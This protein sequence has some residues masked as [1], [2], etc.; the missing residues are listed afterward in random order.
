M[1]AAEEENLER[2]QMSGRMYLP[3]AVRSGPVAAALVVTAEGV[4]EQVVVAAA[5][6][7]RIADEEV[8]PVAQVPHPRRLRLLQRRPS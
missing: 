4:R 8:L 2:L 7:A 5:G 6:L 1:A 3:A